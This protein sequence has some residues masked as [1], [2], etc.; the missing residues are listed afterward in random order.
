MTDEKKIREFVLKCGI[1]PDLLG[2]EYIV[3]AIDMLL[4]QGRV[5]FVELYS[6]VAAA[7]NTTSS[8]A[9]RAMRHAIYSKV[10]EYGG[11]EN[12]E[13]IFHCKILSDH[14]TVGQFLTLCVET[15]KHFE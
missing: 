4:K 9:E 12:L 11:I 6:A 14:L 2:Y 7:H 15:L 3:T 8:R 5:P 13:S 10:E 1:T